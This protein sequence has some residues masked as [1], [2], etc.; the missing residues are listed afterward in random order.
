MLLF[1]ARRSRAIPCSLEDVIIRR[2]DAE[3][4]SM[5]RKNPPNDYTDCGFVYQVP[6]SVRHEVALGKGK[7][8]ILFARAPQPEMPVPIGNKASWLSTLN[9]DVMWVPLLTFCAPP[10]AI[11]SERVKSEYETPQLYPGASHRVTRTSPHLF[12]GARWM[13]GFIE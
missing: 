4:H 7:C 6:S 1:D 11:H 5:N 12:G 10:P 2:A 8:W 9:L 3:F 13:I